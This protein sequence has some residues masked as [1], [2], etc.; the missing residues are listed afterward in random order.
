M[1]AGLIVAALTKGKDGLLAIL[2]RIIHWR[3]HIRW[4]A[5]ILFVPVATSLVA[6]ALHLLFGGMAPQFP[7]LKQNQ[8]M[9]Y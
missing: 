2:R 4:Y 5:F 8:F 9:I 1:L 7:L 6:V 3:V